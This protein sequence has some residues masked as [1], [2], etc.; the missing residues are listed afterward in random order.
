MVGIL[1]RL[2]SLFL[3][4]GDKVVHDIQDVNNKYD[5][6]KEGH[7]SYLTS[8][9]GERLISNNHKAEWRYINGDYCLVDLKTGEIV[10]NQREYWE[11]KR[12]KE[13]ERVLEEKEKE[14]IRRKQEAIDLDK[15]TYRDAIDLKWKRVSDDEI[16]KINNRFTFMNINKEKMCPIVE[17]IL[18][19]SD[20]QFGGFYSI[21]KIYNE[22]DK[23]MIY[24][25][26][27]E[28]I[29]KKTIEDHN[30]I[31]DHNIKIMSYD[32][33]INIY[34]NNCKIVT[35]EYER[36]KGYVLS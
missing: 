30:F 20:H 22:E 1:F 9:D 6:K 31:Y 13:K 4:L 27:Y 10:R 18:L 15:Y 16:C 17:V 23:E 2:I 3:A 28:R 8:Y 11:E 12:R 19:G 7:L 35:E 32:D 21:G 24:K 29:Y 5:S 14:N 25:T 34:I 26:I 36:Q 33:F